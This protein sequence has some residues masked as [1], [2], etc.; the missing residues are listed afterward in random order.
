MVGKS[1]SSIDKKRFFGNVELKSM[2][3]SNVLFVPSGLT[4]PP[5]GPSGRGSLK[6]LLLLTLNLTSSPLRKWQFIGSYGGSINYNFNRNTKPGEFLSNSLRVIASR[7]PLNKLSYGAKLS[8]DY[9]FRN[10]LDT[11]TGKF[12]YRGY[13][14]TGSFSP[15]I[16]TE[17]IPEWTLGGGV[18][19]SPLKNFY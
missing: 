13:N 1:L 6:E 14:L 10:G 18:L 7:S 15:Y 11:N 12:G 3:D 16:K 4:S 17:I 5:E 9:I 19:V 2:Y 8:G